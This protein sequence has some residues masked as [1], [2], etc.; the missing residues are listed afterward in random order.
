[1]SGMSSM[2]V[3]LYYPGE[4]FPPVSITG[5][6]CALRCA[7]CRGH[8]LEH[9]LDGSTPGKLESLCRRLAGEGAAGILLSGGCTPAGKLDLSPLYRSMRRIKTETGLLLNV[10]T[11]LATRAEGAALA[12]AGVDVISFDMVGSTGTIRRVYGTDAT[13]TD[14]EESL[15]A[16]ASLPVPVVPHICIGL[17]Y[18]RIVGEYD[19]IDILAE[20]LPGMAALVFLVLMPTR[21]TPMANVKPPSDEEIMDVIRHARRRLECPLILGCMRPRG[22]PGLELDAVRNGVS[23]IVLPHPETRRVL[24]GT[25]EVKVEKVCCAVIGVER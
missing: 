13:V 5:K 3:T 16:L 25:G 20:H 6:S 21:G 9:M 2:P 15:E 24:E 8:Y 1:L 14:Y 12:D 19:A 23:A 18:G 7:H 22:N 17:D 10:H 4:N 11:G